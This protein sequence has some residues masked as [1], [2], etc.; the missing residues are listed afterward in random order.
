MRLIAYILA[1]Y[2]FGL[3][4]IPCQ[5]N[6]LFVQNDRIEMASVYSHSHHD[7]HTGTD[8]CSPFCQCQCCGS[9]ISIAIYP[10][11]YILFFQK[12]RNNTYQNHFTNHQQHRIMRPPQSNQV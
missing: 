6:H 4:I 10:I 2:I 3:M 5:D 11:R 8:L 7:W 1:V 9:S 12:E